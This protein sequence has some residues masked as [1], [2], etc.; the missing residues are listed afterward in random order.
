MASLWGSLDGFLAASLTVGMIGGIAYSA[1]P[2]LNG[3]AKRRNEGRLDDL[4]GV[5]AADVDDVKWGTMSV[6]SFIPWL[7][8][9]VRLLA[10]E[11]SLL[12]HQPA[13]RSL[14]R[15]AIV[16]ALSVVFLDLRQL[17]ELKIPIIPLH[18]PPSLTRS[19]GA[20]SPPI[21]CG[22]NNHEEKWS[23]P[24]DPSS[25]LKKTYCYCCLFY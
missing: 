7:N 5:E 18:I 22:C 20:I 14:E 17:H 10:S 6:L 24:L 3:D 8:W 4:Q 2:I 21:C 13:T 9:L 12:I 1:I 23:P 25:I 16:S 15:H 19:R 11:P